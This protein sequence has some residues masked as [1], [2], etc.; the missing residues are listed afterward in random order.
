[1]PG[2]K[3]SLHTLMQ[4]LPG[5]NYIPIV[6]VNTCVAERF[7][8]GRKF[9]LFLVFSVFLVFSFQDLRAQTP[10]LIIKPAGAPG[11]TVLDPNGDGYISTKTG[12][13]Q[14]G[15]TIPPDNDVSQSEIP[16]TAIVRPD[17]LSDLLRGPV[18]G[19]CEIVGT[20]AAGN[21]AILVYNDGTNL[22]FRFRLGGY[23][24]NS[25]SY[26]LLIDTD[27]KFGF[28]GAGADPDAVAGN[29]GFE[30]EITLETNFNVK[31]F[32]VNGTVTGTL[33]TSAPYETNCQK[34]IA[35]STASGD[36][37]YFYD[38]YLPLSSLSSLFTSTT[39]L[40]I[41]AVTVMNPDGAIGSNSISD[42]GGITSGSNLDQVF[43][44]LID[45]QTPTPPGQ[46]VLDRSDC[47]A[48]NSPI[49]VGATSISGSSTE[50]SGTIRIYKN[51]IY[52]GQT[53]TNGTWT[54]LNSGMGLEAGDVITATA[55]NTSLNEGESN[56]SCN[57]TTVGSECSSAPFNIALVIADKGVSFNVSVNVPTFITVYEYVAGAYINWKS[58]SVS[59]SGSYSIVEQTGHA[60][61]GGSHYIVANG[62]GLCE[63][64]KVYF[65]VGGGNVVT[66]ANP[67]ITNTAITTAT[68][69][70]S[71]TGVTGATVMLYDGDIQIGTTTI[72]TGTSWSIPVNNLRPCQVISAKQIASSN[73]I[74]G[75]S[76]TLTVTEAA[77]TPVIYGDYCTST[78]ITS[79]SGYSAEAQNSVV[80]LYVNGSASSSGSST[81]DVNGNWIVSSLSVN[82]GSTVTARVT[83]TPNCKTLSAVSNLITIGSQST[84]TA[85]ITGTVYED[86]TSVSG[87]GTNG[88]I[89]K[90][91]IDN[92]YIG[93]TTVSGGWAISTVVDGFS[94]I[95][96][97]G[98]LTVT[99]TSPSNCESTPSTPVTVQCVAPVNT[100]IISKDKVEYC[101]GDNG[102]ISL[103]NSQP[104]VIYTPV[105]SVSPYT[106]VGYSAMGGNG[107]TINMVT[108]NLAIDQNITV[109]ATKISSV[110][111]ETYN[112]NTLFIDVIPLP[113]TTYAVSPDN[114]TLCEGNSIPVTLSATESNNF[115]YYLEDAVTGEKLSAT[116]SGNAGS[117]G[118]SITSNSIYTTNNIKV[119]ATNK[120]TGCTT[121]LPD[122][123]TVTLQGPDL[124][125]AVTAGQS[126]LCSN[127]S[128]SISVATENNANY[129][130][131]V[132][133]SGGTII[134]VPFTGNGTVQSVSTGILAASE[135]YYA[136]V[137]NI[138]C[139]TTRLA[140][141]VSVTVADIS[142]SGIITQVM[143]YGQANGTVEVTA[144]GGT[145]GYNY[146]WSGGEITS[147][148]SGKSAGTYT[149]T[150]TDNNSCTAT[151][152][153]T[154]ST[155]VAP[156]SVATT[157]VKNVTTS[158][159]SNGS[160]DVAASGGTPTFTYS[161]DGVNFQ[162][163]NKFNALTE[164]NYTITAKDLSGCTATTSGT[165][166][167]PGSL[168][169]TGT[170][171]DVTCYGG[172]NGAI[173]ITPPTGGTEPYLYSIDNGTTFQLSAIF[174]NLQ[175]GNYSIKV[176]DSGSTVLYG[177]GIFIVNQPGV[178]TA[179]TV[180]KNVSCYNGI[181]GAITLSSIA[182]GI[183]PFTFDW[184]ND[185]T[186]DFNDSQNLA[187]LKAGPF[188]LTIKDANNCTAS[189]SFMVN[190]PAALGISGV[191]TNVTVAGQSTG[192]VLTSIT[193][194]NPDY[195][196]SWN[197]VP[198][199]TTQNLANVAAGSYSLTITDANGCGITKPF[200]VGGP[201]QSKTG[202]PYEVAD[203][204]S[205]S[206]S[207][208]TGTINWPAQ[209]NE[210]NDD[211]NIADGWIR[212]SAARNFTGSSGYLL[213]IGAQVRN[214]S[215]T[216]PVSISR[217]IDLT[218]VSS[219]TVKF[220][221]SAIENKQNGAGSVKVSIGSNFSQ[222]LN[223]SNALTS[224]FS[225]TITSGLGANSIIKFELNLS[226]IVDNLLLIDN[227]EITYNKDLNL[228]ATPT[229]LICNGDNSGEIAVSVTGGYT[230]YNYS[231]TGPNPFT[232]T[233]KDLT[234]L[235]A[236]VY[237]LNL[238]GAGGCNLNADVV[239]S[240]PSPLNVFETV[241]NVSCFGGTDGS[242]DIFTV[243]GT[244][245]Y[246]YAWT[247]PVTFNSTTENISGLLAGTYH[248]TVTDNNGCI[249]TKYYT[250]EQPLLLSATISQAGISCFNESDGS[251]TFGSPTG[252]SGKFQFSIDGGSTW[253]PLPGTSANF[254]FTG[255]SGGTYQLQM[256]DFNVQ[257]CAVSFTN[258]ILSNPLQL[259]G[260]VTSTNPTCYLGSNGTITVSATG[261]SGFYNY[262]IDSGISW[263]TSGSFTNLIDSSYD[264]MIRDANHHNCTDAV[265][266]VTL[267]HPDEFIVNGPLADP[268][269]GEVCVGGSVTLTINATG[270]TLPYSY[271]WQSSADNTTF[272]NID[273]Q[274]SVSY[275]PL[276][277]NAGT[278]YYRAIVSNSGTGCAV[279]TSNPV[280]VTANAAPASGTLTPSPT[281]GAV[282]MGS[283]VSATATPGSGGSG[284]IADVLQYR[285][286]TGSWTTYTSGSG[287][288][289]TGYTSA[290]IRT[291]RTSTSPG[292]TTSA[293]VV[294]TWSVNANLTAVISGGSTPIC[295][296]T[297]PGIFT[298][299]GGGGTGSYTY[300]WY[301]D[302]TATGVT[303][304]T[305]SPGNLTATSA[306]YCAITSGTCGTVNTA[307][308][309][310]TV[311]E[312]PTAVISYS[313]TPFCKSLNAPQSVSL[314]GTSAYSGGNYSSTAGLSIDSGTGA[315]LPFTSTA[316]T[317][318][319]TYSTPASGGCNEV[320][321]T[322]SVSIISDLVWTGAIDTDWNAQG[323]W[324]CN[325]VPDMTTNVQIPDVTNKPILSSGATGGA[326]NIVIE[327]GSTL[328]VTGNTLQIAGTI[329]STGAF[330]ATAGTVEMTGVLAQT[331][332]AGTFSTNTVQN[333]TASN[334][335]GVTLDGDLNIT[336]ILKANTGGLNITADKTLTLISTA[337]QTALIDGTGTGEVTGNVTMQRFLSSA[338]GYKYFGSPFSN[339]TAA[340]FSSYLS[341]SAI[342]PTFYRNDENHKNLPGTGEDMSGWIAYSAGNLNPM[343][344]YAANLGSNLTP[345][346]ISLS[347]VV[348]NGSVSKTLYNH[349]GAYTQGF[350]LI[351]NPYP[352][353]IDW[354]SAGWTKT[355]IDNA[356]YFFD[357]TGAADQYSGVY[358]YLVD[359]VPSSNHSSIIPSMQGFF[360][361]VTD[362]S[363]PVTGSLGMSNN[364]RTND[365]NP[366]FKAAFVD[367]RTILRFA[368]TFETKN[369]T[370][371]AAV[372]YFDEQANRSF[373]KDKDALKM[374]NTDLLVPNI[375]TLSTDPK[376]LSINGM[377]FP[378]DSITKIPLGITTLSDGWINFS[379]KEISQL[380][381]DVH[382][383]LVDSEKGTTQD[384]KQH[385]EY[386]FYLKK[387]EYNARF[388]IVFSHSDLSA[389]PSDTGK[390]F[391][392]S[393]SSNLLMVNVNLPFNTKGNLI[394]TNMLG[395]VILQK[396]VYE[397]ETVEVNPYGG[398]SVFVVTMISGKRKESEKI[399]IRKDYE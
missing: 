395:Q 233:S 232:A 27:G 97:G 295:H 263:S 181:N 328:T 192:G 219:I 147:N 221:Y 376:Q 326:K 128:T 121:D 115:E 201:I 102:I 341:T 85:T 52:V 114:I 174:S 297:T 289:T 390:M 251:I 342:L 305:Y 334:P 330:T 140:T 283:I 327:N 288:N 69:Q 292:C 19:F 358:S 188:A 239:V 368:A 322:T 213:E 110:A 55:Q 131:T 40:R 276:T 394:V 261:G 371:D 42:I 117:N 227:L 54:Y 32:N 364:I 78:T 308:S 318:I 238:T 122:Q 44:D 365:L 383:Y 109:K 202:C 63:S 47:P 12:G 339:A 274:T 18:G 185:G 284:T 310:I 45:A 222:S 30:A 64:S 189:F 381:A 190:E 354:N 101:Q 104:G 156:L 164:G 296:G 138:G 95:Y 324:S 98:K 175:A 99:T 79:I 139:G 275:E 315:I 380:D 356:I 264:I 329:T 65:C 307:T 135:N 270:G 80:N 119:V 216:V 126:V 5:Y 228:T 247:G 207:N 303:T 100:Q 28:T 186:G 136:E 337:T 143:C 21:N 57:A 241:T 302:G 317:Y 257:A 155:P 83:D 203:D 130:Y 33:V 206:Y 352:A 51:G 145:P 265:S 254:S 353:P 385:P 272:A 124:N 374:L 234:N 386:R 350:N 151:A 321:V 148:I 367:P 373:D 158:G 290:E 43:T 106:V 245:P 313:G 70:I 153:Y 141:T 167:A 3:L 166:G 61:A 279:I 23:A 193:G 271:Q 87:T 378:A 298:A 113:N 366:A 96:A 287:L 372:I 6:R 285:F 13:I 268:L 323:N 340:Q 375:Y 223:L 36:P 86:R 209:W 9:S 250:V 361:H 2:C 159:G 396:A 93:E 82:S 81:V 149:I 37:D 244:A 72:A 242:I 262:S 266:T 4:F 281:Q 71:G 178:I 123:I 379:A 362:G 49:A 218:D 14:L 214:Q 320:S 347:G 398:S 15:F 11:N 229:K 111:C 309:T 129:T 215:I 195:I 88:T 133:N 273:G 240:E 154:I 179:T 116:I 231:W 220:D 184:N 132:K 363:F 291:Y 8:A 370:E 316:G 16:Y 359:G 60:L 269:S 25:K 171:T 38:F 41:V 278:I 248:L 67:V 125:M 17:P 68:T 66:T 255:L 90:L 319:V 173:T 300:L 182:G 62:S 260:S 137:T 56:Q 194:G 34:S 162:T 252:G 399:L 197:S 331:I 226:G 76:N 196:Y 170:V 210:S 22:L 183:A 267:T 74:S 212:E 108:N 230:P 217:V 200:Y 39:A 333:L 7:H 26:S 20:D 335:I 118:I 348:N 382:I 127:Q 211:N 59:S 107:T 306:F 165:V 208:S 112:V 168:L 103:S 280:T 198:A 176:K 351:A 169:V 191:V 343:E 246:T 120:I 75:S 336:G 92:G 84:N 325:V 205:N 397:M 29:A 144:T 73:C 294:V 187:D 150:V 346:T 286:D 253:M 180:I 35:L 243:G 163:S 293:P 46:E 360:V 89:V 142:L 338:F 50:T 53:T 357:A 258:Q 199:Q 393:R 384:L 235:A 160:I 94:E 299:T 58:I 134:G 256:R 344:G 332:P 177:S 387:G 369:A 31:A 172:N 392:L 157:L 249:F 304:Q 312:I 237:S 24:P 259:I 1:M 105:L 277:V 282:C 355:N 314:S 389:L 161:I 391:T 10:G 152:E 204:F 236:G 349:N 224:S 311:T 48:I 91:Y 301:K 377:P 225:H 345:A 77:S 146:L 388:S